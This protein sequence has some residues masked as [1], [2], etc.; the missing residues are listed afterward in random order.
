VRFFAQLL[1][2]N[3]IVHEMILSCH[4]STIW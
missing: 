1:G 2:V 4:G 3:D